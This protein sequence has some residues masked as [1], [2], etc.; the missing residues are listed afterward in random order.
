[1][2][3]TKPRK[4]FTPEFKAQAIELL[5]I[6]SPVAELTEE[7][8]IS[9][10]PLYSW[11]SS[12]QG[13]RVGSE[14]GRAVGEDAAADDPRALRR[15]NVVLRQENEIFKKAAVILGTKTPPNY[16]R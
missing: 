1:M 13:A 3:H 11:E 9:A 10:N 7:L 6:G 15:E 14:G 16:G 2:N 8:C 4:Q 12:S 5:A